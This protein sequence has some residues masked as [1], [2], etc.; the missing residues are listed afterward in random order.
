MKHVQTLV[1]S[2]QIL[3]KD[4]F[5]RITN[6]YQELGIVADQIENRLEDLEN[7]VKEKFRK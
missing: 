2:E 1:T 6:T 5:D 3:F 4:I 7:Q